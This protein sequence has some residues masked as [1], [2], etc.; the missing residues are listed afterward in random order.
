[1]IT[2]GQQFQAFRSTRSPGKGS[3]SRLRGQF[4]LTYHKSSPISVQ[5]LL[6]S[7]AIVFLQWT[8]VSKFTGELRTGPVS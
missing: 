5:W 7:L 2:F 6:N 8:E 1:V 4:L 3:Y